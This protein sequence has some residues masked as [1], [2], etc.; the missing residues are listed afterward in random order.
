MSE[1]TNAIRAI[2]RGEIVVVTDD[3]RRENEGDLIMA[4]EAVSTRSRS[5]SST[6]RA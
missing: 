1:I 3:E 6:A 5:S 4:A 2:G